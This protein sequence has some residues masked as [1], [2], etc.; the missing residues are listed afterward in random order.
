[1]P[2]HRMYGYNFWVGELKGRGIVIREMDIPSYVKEG[3]VML[4]LTSTKEY[5]QYEYE[6]IQSDFLSEREFLDKHGDISDSV[7][8]WCL[9]AMET[10]HACLPTTNF[11]EDDLEGED[12]EESTY[13]FF[14]ESGGTRA[15]D[16]SSG[17]RNVT[18]RISD[19][20]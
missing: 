4:Y 6:L 1:M 3:Y 12:E 2:I 15:Y 10:D 13:R 14:E 8:T 17:L 11:R 16:P 9:A 5:R 19:D 18:I 20:D 7:Y